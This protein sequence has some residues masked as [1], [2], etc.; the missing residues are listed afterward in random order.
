MLTLIGTLLGGVFRLLPE[1]FKFL[2][3]KNDRAHELAML[4]KQIE[5]D[6]LKA[7]QAVDLTHAQT[8]GAATIED[9]KALAVAVQA[10]ATQTGVR[11]VDGL[12]SL[13]RPIL[14]F[15]WCLGLYT[16]ALVADWWALVYLSKVPMI[17]AA[18]QVWGPDEKAIVASIFSFWF[19]DRAL[20][21]K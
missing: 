9:I 4:D 7:Q 18:L 10:Q 19:V 2:D 12:N 3:A 1:L 8:E 6:K 16:A 20:R 17:E 15:W 21:K 5:A 14:T 13:V 11:W